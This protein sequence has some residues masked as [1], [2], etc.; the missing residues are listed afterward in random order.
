VTTT[1]HERRRAI[2]FLLVATVIWGAV[3]PINRAG[4]LAVRA[5]LERAGAAGGDIALTAPLL[6]LVLRFVVA[7]VAASLLPG[8]WRALLSGR[9]AIVDVLC[10]GLPFFLGFVLQYMGIADTSATVA[11]F[12]TSAYV[13]LV[14]AIGV[15][16][17]R[18]RPPAALVAG[19]FVTA[20]GI[21]ALV[22]GLDALQGGAP[23][24]FGRGEALSLAC[25][26][27]FAVQVHAI[28]RAARRTHPAALTLGTM[29]LTAALA[30]ALLLCL[31][32]GRLSV[33]PR[34][35]SAVISD[36]T[37]AG[38]VTYSALLASVVAVE[39]IYR[40]Q[41]VVTPSR[42]AII[43]A[44]EPAFAAAFAWGF[45]DELFGAA[46]MTGCCLILLGNLVS[47]LP[48]REP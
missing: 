46:A 1:A 43:Y 2:F 9:D 22:G 23:A 39:I 14:P 6:Y 8:A 35:L 15:I 13:V 18:R 48:R 5:S 25:A 10:V 24:K 32:G 33:T 31:S 47:E 30:T 37:V 45:A 27:A 41:N 17:H 42:A 16:A 26:F 11:A 29:L 19:A 44:A 40:Y 12:L 4:V 36:T 34:V 28:E 21:T 20:L 3:F 38:A 7:A